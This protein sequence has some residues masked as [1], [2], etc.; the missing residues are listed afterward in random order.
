LNVVSFWSEMSGG[1]VVICS[2]VGCPLVPLNAVVSL[3]A[4]G[5]VGMQYKARVQPPCRGRVHV[6]D[7]AEH[8]HANAVHGVIYSISV[9]CMVG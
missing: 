7:Y 4:A 3:C 9:S 1:D 8:M 2:I 5:A 6:L